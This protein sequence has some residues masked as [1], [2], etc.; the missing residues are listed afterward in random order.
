MKQ[1]KTTYFRK[2]IIEIMY[3][4]KHII[5]GTEYNFFNAEE[6]LQLTQ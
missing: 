1:W 4:L 3:L 2:D 6:L 5:F